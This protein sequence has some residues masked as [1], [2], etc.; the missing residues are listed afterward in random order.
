MI[1]DD[2]A[3]PFIGGADGLRLFEIVGLSTY[4]KVGMGVQAAGILVERTGR[5]RPPTTLSARPRAVPHS[6]RRTSF[7]SR[8]GLPD[9]REL[10]SRLRPRVRRPARKF[11]SLRS[12]E[13]NAEKHHLRT[14]HACDGGRVR[15]LGQEHRERARDTHALLVA[16]GRVD[17]LW[18]R[19]RLLVGQHARHL[20]PEL[21]S[22]M[23]AADPRIG[24]VRA[25]YSAEGNATPGRRP[26]PRFP[27]H[28]VA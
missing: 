24:R 2:H 19:L 21:S 16:Q 8:S 15:W 10:V 27:S 11:H 17:L 23:L 12:E 18:D 22:L 4:K 28:A 5:A 7:G 1:G 13:L 26:E 20:R 25:P 3:A 9:G 14:L 6:D